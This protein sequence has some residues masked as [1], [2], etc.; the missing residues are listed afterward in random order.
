MGELLIETLFLHGHSPTYFMAD[1]LPLIYD[2]D[3]SFR[4]L[5]SFLKRA[6]NEVIKEKTASSKYTDLETCYASAGFLFKDCLISNTLTP[7][8]WGFA[9]FI[10]TAGF[11]ENKKNI[12]TVTHRLWEETS[13]IWR[14]EWRKD[15]DIIVPYPGKLESIVKVLPYVSDLLIGFTPNNFKHCPAYVKKSI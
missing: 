12:E 1:G 6:A 9:H 8:N 7:Y 14:Y 10:K 5:H 2:A 11:I 13:S 4:F 15:D 3:R